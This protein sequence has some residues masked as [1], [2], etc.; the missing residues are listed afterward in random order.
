MGTM[1][2][3]LAEVV[4]GDDGS[5]VVH[6]HG[7][8]DLATAPAVEAAIRAALPSSF[9]RLVFDLTDLRFMDSSGISVLLRLACDAPSVAVRNPTP[10]VAMVIAATGLTEILPVAD[11]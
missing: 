10:T 1:S 3:D 5:V 4:R 7:E 8:V 11:D 2:E 6:L 9:E